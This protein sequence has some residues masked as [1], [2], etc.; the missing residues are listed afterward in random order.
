ML[1][2]L[3]TTCGAALDG[4]QW[5]RR[6]RN[7]EMALH[8]LS[9]HALRDLGIGRSEIGAVIHR[10]GEASALNDRQPWSGS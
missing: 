3:L 2:S 9:D 10:C 5:R 6:L 8:A 4:L 7:D 1:Q